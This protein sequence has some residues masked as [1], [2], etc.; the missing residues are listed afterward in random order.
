MVAAALSVCLIGLG[1]AAE[2]HASIR[3]PT[4]I[5]AQRLGS[6]LRELAKEQKFQVL[7]RSD[8]VR[9]LVS[10]GA[11]GELTSD[12]ALTQVLRGTGLTYRYLDNTTVTILPVSATGAPTQSELGVQD[13]TQAERKEGKNS[14]SEKFRVAQV[15]QG[16]DA[17]STAVDKISA[18]TKSEQT[19][20]LEEVI[21]TA[22]K[23]EERLIDVPISIVA[24]SA[25]E[26]AKRNAVGIDNLSQ[27]VPGLAIQSSSSYQRRIYLRGVSNTSGTS[28]SVG[29]Y[30]DEAAVTASP[31]FQLDLRTYDLERVEVL[32]GPQGTL[33]GEGSMGGT[34]RF[35][36]RDP[37]LDRFAM[38]AD[39]AALFTENGSP[40]QRI[41]SV[42]NVPLIEN[43]LGLRIAGTF[44][45]E[46]GW[47]DS[48]A[49]D[50]KDYNDENLVDVRV[51]GLWRPASEFSLSAMAIIHRNAAAPNN[52]ADANGNF[53]PVLNL[54]VTPSSQDDYDIYNLT[55]S[56][57]FASAR[58]LSTTS[59][60]RQTQ[61]VKDA[62]SVFPLLQPPAPVFDS[63]LPLQALAAK[64]FTEELRLT[65]T[66]SGPWQWTIGGFYRHFRLDMDQPQIYFAQPGPPGSPLPGSFP[67]EESS[68]SR[69]W[70]A[71][72]DTSYK[73]TNRFTLGV[74]LRYFSDN[75]DDTSIFGG[76]PTALTDGRFHSTSPRAYA[77]YKLTDEI[78]TYASAAKGFRSGGFNGAGLPNFGPEQIWTYELGAKMSGWDGR[79]RS[80]A[81]IFYSDYTNYQIT[82]ILPSGPPIATTNNSGNVHIEGFE[83]GLSWRPTDDWEFALNGDYLHSRFYEINSRE[84]A[85][86]VGDPLDL[87]PKYNF[88]VSAQRNFKWASKAGFCRVDY[89][90]QG[91][92]VYRNREFGP[93]FFGESDI[94]E[95]LNFNV[96]L[97][98]ND[99]LLLGILGQNLLDD[100]GLTDALGI[101][102]LASRPRPRTFGV[103]FSAK[104]N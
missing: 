89:S 37:E 77:Q 101:Q 48:P 29:V 92:E 19:V 83:L 79:L 4:N 18:A 85:Y 75:Q 7:F 91:R 6:A 78:E 12:E 58:V 36:T 33:Y 26:L 8:L 15:D 46:G 42:V 44:D 45:H 30:L 70:A 69:S 35:I 82:G 49:A 14:S 32:R 50:R 39:V 102:G 41:E 55:A 51:K 9:D 68:V 16:R 76:P 10:P 90:Q 59:Y 20:R 25:D 99:S 87:T 47:I 64:T 84:P 96:G 62:Q 81:A 40:G 73:L 34:I 66:G 100:H 24:L 5:A 86:N 56:Y 21:V 60:I 28:S 97:Q 31:N 43:Q 54:T 22:Q 72:G 2:A 61:D 67:Y 95:M 94:I 1:I 65:S 80:D 74:G 71:F 38:N 103:Y 63:Y 27:A 11:V 23:R 98:W 13:G 88:T 53:T 52:G 93:W 17:S 3:T 104:F 57:D